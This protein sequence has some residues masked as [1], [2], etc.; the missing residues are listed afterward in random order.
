MSSSWEELI[1]R[2]EYTEVGG[3]GA[4]H[5][6]SPPSHKLKE[7]KE[8]KIK[9]W[10]E[11]ENKFF[12]LQYLRGKDS[13]LYTCKATNRGGELRY[14]LFHNSLPLFRVHMHRITVGNYETGL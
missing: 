11:N 4:P 10:R 3:Q 7:E 12:R 1:L 14:N 5:P 6:P 2:D 8:E 13:G 9:M